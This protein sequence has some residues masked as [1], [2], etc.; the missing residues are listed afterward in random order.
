[1]PKEEKATANVDKLITRQMP[2]QIVEAK[3][4]LE[5]Y[6]NSL[7]RFLRDA[8]ELESF[9][10][11][12]EKGLQGYDPLENREARNEREETEAEEDLD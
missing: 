3:R 2:Q 1:M 4:T 12:L 5:D 7:D 8:P 10:A 11:A 6:A 9:E